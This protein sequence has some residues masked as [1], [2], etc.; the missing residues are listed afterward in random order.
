MV[1]RCWIVKEVGQTLL[2]IFIRGEFDTKSEEA[3]SSSKL[4]IG[5]G[6]SV[7]FPI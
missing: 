7:A 4:V 3:T 6:H 5:H 1:S 2:E